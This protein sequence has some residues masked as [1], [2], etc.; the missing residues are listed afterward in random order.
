MMRCEYT[1]FVKSIW[2]DG[3]H[4]KRNLAV[5]GLGL[6]GECGEVCEVLLDSDNLTNARKLVDECGDVLYYATILA[7]WKGVD[8]IH[9]WPLAVPDLTDKHI[10]GLMLVRD[11][12]EVS[13]RVK[14]FIRDGANPTE[15]TLW[16]LLRRILFGLERV[17]KN[18]GADLYDAMD[19]NV[20][21]LEVRYAERLL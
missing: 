6:I 13:E 5:A 21:K 18:V 14:K 3:E 15:E 2:M 4:R 17:L 19:Q 7:D 11:A 1:G 8:V 12:K 20:A 16:P 10:A 9:I